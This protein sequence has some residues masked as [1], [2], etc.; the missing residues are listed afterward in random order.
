MKKINNVLQN[1]WTGYSLLTILLV[2]VI[3]FCLFT[4]KT[5]ADARAVQTELEN[6]QNLLETVEN[7][8]SVA[9]EYADTIESQLE[10]TNK[11]LEE[12]NTEL[13]ALTE[14]V[15]EIE[16]NM[17]ESKQVYGVVIT[18]S[19]VKLLAKTVWG[20]ARGL[21]DLERSMVVWCI[22]NRVDAGGGTISQVIKAE[23]QFHG[24]SPSF[25]VQDDIVDL[26]R[27]V[28]AR[29]QL[30]KVCAGDVGRTLPADYTYFNAKNGHNVYRNKYQ[31]N[32]DIW[33]ASDWNKIWNPYE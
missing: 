13:T 21:N 15:A 8:L 14:D 16:A 32:Y 26:V 12:K 23:G 20:E 11:E 10:E 30:E 7:D 22:L 19:D 5:S 29:W 31:G 24:Y 1:K 25:P 2:F 27:D 18:D 28:I 6:T 9:S 17:F 4:A 3:V 33:D